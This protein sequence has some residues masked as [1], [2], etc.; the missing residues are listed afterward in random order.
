MIRR[1]PISTRT[2]TLFPYTTLFR[3]LRILRASV[4]QQV[5]FRGADEV[6]LAQAAHVVGGIPDHAA[7]VVHAAVGMVVFTVGHVCQR[8]HERHRAVIILEAIGLCQRVAVLRH[9][10]ARDLW[11]P[12]LDAGLGALVLAHLARLGLGRVGGGQS[13]QFG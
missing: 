3:S 1:P 12:F 8:V 10:P 11:Q 6:V 5:G 4:G 2:Y 9:L 7:V 13:G